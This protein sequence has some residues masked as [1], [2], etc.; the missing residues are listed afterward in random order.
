MAFTCGVDRITEQVDTNWHLQTEAALSQAH[1]VTPTAVT[2]TPPVATDAAPAAAIL[3]LQPRPPLPMLETRLAAFGHACERIDECACR[4][5]RFLAVRGGS[6]RMI[7]VN[8]NGALRL[9]CA[10]KLLLSA[11]F[12]S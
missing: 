6:S 11:S 1:A 10:R 12:D 9:S 8:A 7:T 5:M 2:D 3:L 4:L